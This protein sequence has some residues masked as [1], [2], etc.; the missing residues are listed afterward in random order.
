LL[1]LKGELLLMQSTEASAKTAEYL[2]LSG[3][4]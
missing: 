3:D 4:G 2:F 1:R